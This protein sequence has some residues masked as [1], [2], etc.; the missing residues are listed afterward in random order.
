MKWKKG[1]NKKYEKKGC[2]GKEKRKKEWR[3]WMKAEIKEIKILYTFAH[4]L[5]YWIKIRVLTASADSE[6]FVYW[7]T[8]VFIQIYSMFCP[9]MSYP[10]IVKRDDCKLN[11]HNSGTYFQKWM[12]AYKFQVFITNNLNLLRRPKLLYQNLYTIIFI[13]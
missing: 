12:S 13:G 8:K 1:G 5:F 10:F 4:F 9:A 6:C 3:N 7:L 2:D 11:F